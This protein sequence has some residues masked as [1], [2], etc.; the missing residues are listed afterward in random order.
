[1]FRTFSIVLLAVG[2]TPVLNA[3]EG[4]HAGAAA[5]ETTPDVFP[6]RLRSGKSHLVH[7]PLHARAVA[8]Q[9]GEGRV[10]ITIVDA[11][12]LGR[13]ELDLVKA[14]AAEAT[15]WKPE[16]MLIAATHSHTTPSTGGEDPGSVAYREKRYNGMVGAITGAIANLEPAAAGFGS[17]DEPSEVR[18]RRWFLEE[19]TMPPNPFG[20]YDKVKMNP[21][22]NHLVKPAAPVDPEICVIDVRDRRGK[23]L[24]LIAN[25]ALHYVTGVPRQIID[26]RE[27]G[28][29]S[30]DYFGEFA[31]VMPYRMAH[32][33]SENY[34]AFMS[35]GTSG[36]INNNA[37]GIERGGRAP[38]EQCRIVASKAAD[39]AW[40]ATR[41]IEHDDNPLIAVRQREITLTYRRVTEEQVLRALE[42]MK[43]IEEKGEDEFPKKALQYA[44]NTVKF[45]EPREPE[46]VIIQVIRIGDQAICTLPFE[47]L[48]EIGLELKEKSPFPHTFTIELANGS[49]GYLPPPNQ[50]ELGGYETWI[51]TCR[52]VPESSEI[53]VKNL[54]EMLDELKAL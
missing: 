30:A 18:N 54:L 52:F 8:F 14:E 35:N 44:R 6:V 10:V 39:A 33:P 48:V 11:I 32:N 19:G 22:Y 31:R 34:V 47:V 28:M 4:L 2:L 5:V 29:A 51:G 9:N 20:E 16:E 25:Y 40:R 41:E 21:G 26:G 23:P 53:L 15:G 42:T 12:G 43:G 27:V 37:F 13:E 50:F 3:A 17:E 46:K 1:M 45:Q 7:D 49:Y 38:F 36:D 24:G